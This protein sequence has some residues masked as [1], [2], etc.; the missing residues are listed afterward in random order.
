S[1]LDVDGFYVKEG[2]KPFEVLVDAAAARLGDKKGLIE[3]DVFEEAGGQKKDEKLFSARGL[4]PAKEKLVRD[5]YLG[6]RSAVLKSADL[7][8]VVKTEVVDGKLT[9]SREAIGPADRVEKAAGLRQDD[10][11][12]PIPVARLVVKIDRNDEIKAD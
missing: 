10:F 9:L 8:S 11:V 6:L 12:N 1:R 4:P 7:K 5:S 2:V 3:I